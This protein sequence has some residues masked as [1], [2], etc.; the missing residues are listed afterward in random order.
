MC[1]TVPA[2]ERIVLS[3]D[4][5]MDGWASTWWPN[6]RPEWDKTD[7]APIE[8]YTELTAGAEEYVATG[9]LSK[10]AFAQT[11]VVQNKISLKAIVFFMVSSISEHELKALKVL[12]NS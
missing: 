11:N 12:V 6:E 8:L 1:E 2:S 4:D 3:C 5:P 7:G 10:P 9:P